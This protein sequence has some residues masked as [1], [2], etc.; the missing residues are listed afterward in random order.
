MGANVTIISWV[1]DL[2]VKLCACILHLATNG[3]TQDFNKRAWTQSIKS[4]QDNEARKAATQLPIRF[5]EL[6]DALISKY[7]SPAMARMALTL[8][9]GTTALRQRY[10]PDVEYEGKQLSVIKINTR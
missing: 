2:L 1:D 7:S 4:M 5:T 9:Y 8:L 3:A 10:S 6:P